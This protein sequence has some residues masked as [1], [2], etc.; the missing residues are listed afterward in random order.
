[1]LNENEVIN[2][3]LGYDGLKIIQR[4]DM[5][6]FSLDSTLLANFV[7][8]NKNTDKIVDL[9]TGN[10]PIPLFLSVRTKAKIIGIEIQKDAFE[11]AKRNVKINN[12]EQQIEIINADLKNI[13][14]KI[15]HH[16]F[17]LVTSNPP[18]FKVTNEANVNKNDYLTIARHEIL[19]T[20]EDVIKEA[21]LLLKHGGY[22]TMVHRPDRLLDI[23]GLL[24]DYKL[25]PKRLRLVYPKPNKE[26]NTILIEARKSN[27]GGLRILPPLYVYDESNNYTETI[28][29]MFM[30]K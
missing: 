21:S 15:G 29:K 20:L 9:G 4:P 27:Q 2:D 26:C 11:L 23:L 30:M 24:R 13:Y 22:F 25:E 17:E 6:N 7:T 8:I 12:L 5:F 3:L 16:T 10:G 28:R 14:Q 19:V 18:Y 1:M